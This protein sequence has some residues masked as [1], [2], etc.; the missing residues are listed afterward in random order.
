MKSIFIIIVVLIVCYIFYKTYSIQNVDKNLIQ[1]INKGAVILDVRTKMEYENGHIP[2]SVNIA[3]SKL[4]AA[5]INLDKK[6]T[7][8]TCCSHGLR[9]IKAVE[10]L[11]V[12]GFKDVHNGGAWTDLEKYTN[13]KQNK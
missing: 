11:K 7:I 1:L 8:I 13:N 5:S 10:I 2:G 3:L 9:S 6:Q 4:R 12:R